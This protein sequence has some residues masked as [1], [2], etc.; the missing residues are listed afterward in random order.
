MSIRLNNF[1]KYPKYKDPSASLRTGSGV[2]WI[3]KI[4]MQWEIERLRY[5][6]KEPIESGVGEPAEFQRE[7]WPRYIRIT[8]IAGPR[9]LRKDTFYSLPPEVAS[10][11]PVRKGDVLFASAGATYGRSYLHWDK[12]GEFCYAGYL[13]KFTPSSKIEPRYV[14]YWAQSKFFWDQVRS[15]VIQS[16]IQN[17]SATKY[18]DLSILIPSMGEQKRMADFLDEKAGELDRFVKSNKK[19]IELLKEYRQKII[20]AVV[21][22]KYKIENGKLQKRS[23]SELKDSGIEWLGEIPEAWEVKRLKHVTRVNPLKSS[24]RS[25]MKLE[26]TFL[27]M[28]NVSEVGDLNLS[29][30]RE[31]REV[32]DGYTYFEDEDVVVAKITPCFENGKGAYLEGLKNGIGFGSTEFHVF[33]SAKTILPKYLYLITVSHLFRR[34]G[35]ASMHGAAGQKRVPARFVKNFTIGVPPLNQQRR[36]IDGVEKRLEKIAHMVKKLENQNRKI[37]EYK[38]SLIYN[39]VTGKVR[40]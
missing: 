9:D 32:Y 8:D 37:Q 17:F 23:E 21:T 3:D 29:E 19:Q 5:V 2:E 39:V 15:G 35:E 4:P 40:L 31:V 38:K 13:V 34:L 10:R 30:T 20:T 36:L 1:K 27:P 26:V 28:E 7:D 25:S 11:A 18:K 33:R 22:G 24:F 12:E 6:A 14:S 16:T